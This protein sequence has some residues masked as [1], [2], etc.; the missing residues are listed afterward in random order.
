MIAHTVTCTNTNGT[1]TS[2]LYVNDA[3]FTT[4]FTLYNSFAATY[5]YQRIG[6]REDNVNNYWPG[7]IAN[8]RYYKRP[9]TTAE[10]STLYTSR[11]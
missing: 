3:S 4:T 2:V 6:H 5:G 7:Y 11:T 8:V 9:L 1:A 10:I